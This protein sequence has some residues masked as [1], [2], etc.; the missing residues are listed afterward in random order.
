MKNFPK[1]FLW[2][3]STSSHQIEGGLLNNWSVWEEQNAVR[4]VRNAPK[5]LEKD[6][7]DLAS[8]EDCYKSN[9]VYSSES[10]KYWRKDIEVLKKLSLNSY[11]FSIEWSRIEPE[12]GSF[13]KE[14][15][16]YYIEIIK[17]LRENNIEPVIT[18]WHWTI[19]VWLDSEGGLMAKDFLFYW[20]RFAEYVVSNM[21]EGVKYWLTINEPGV[22]GFLSYKSGVWPPCKKNIFEFLKYHIYIFPKSHKI[23]Y[24]IVKERFPDSMVSFA[25]QAPNFEP[26]NNRFYNKIVSAVS[27]YITNY[28]N[29]DLVRKYMDF[30]AI[31]FYFNNLVGIKGFKNTDDIVTDLGWW[32]RPEKL[33]DILKKLYRRYRLPIIIT[34]NGLADYKD[35]LR[36]EWIKKS[37]EAIQ[38]CIGDGVNIFGYLHWSLIDNFEWAEGFWPRFGL[39]KI[40]YKTKERIIRDSAYYYSKIVRR[41]GI[42]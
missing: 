8:K 35:T 5:R 27:N 17:E 4:L 1:G 25:H 30:M 42:M 6:L 21:G 15:L 12:K 3:A 7:Y 28:F 14:G 41:N 19:P 10:F 13:S 20:E 16:E 24:K 18:I 31:N 23:A 2:G 40:D 9:S 33:E 38:N 29:I 39:A 26:Y 36:K 34:E 32:Y 37:I 22:V 11:R